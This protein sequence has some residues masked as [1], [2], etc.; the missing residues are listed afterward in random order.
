MRLTYL[1]KVKIEKYL[2][3]NSK[4]DDPV[5][6]CYVIDDEILNIYWNKDQWNAEWIYKEVLSD[7]EIFEIL[8]Q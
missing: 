5:T 8:G 3:K 6:K 2:V 4:E 1:Q 7:M